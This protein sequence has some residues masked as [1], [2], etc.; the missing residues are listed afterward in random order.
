M[1]KIKVT[2]VAFPD[3]TNIWLKSDREY[4]LKCVDAWKAKL[5]PEMREQC[6]THNLTMVAGELS[7][8]EE[9]YH[10]IGASNQFPWPE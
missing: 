3:G 9:D 7:M 2:F 4:L 10:R 8:L 5:L 6:E 1:S